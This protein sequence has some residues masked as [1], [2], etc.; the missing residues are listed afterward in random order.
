MLPLILSQKPQIYK[1]ILQEIFQFLTKGG[2]ENSAPP[3]VTV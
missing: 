3:R 2:A 1:V